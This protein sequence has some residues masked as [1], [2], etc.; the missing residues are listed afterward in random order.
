[1]PIIE[2]IVMPIR[3]AICLSLLRNIVTISFCQSCMLDAVSC[4]IFLATDLQA[5]KPFGKQIYTLASKV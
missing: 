4:A 1:M 3:L 5:G 2:D